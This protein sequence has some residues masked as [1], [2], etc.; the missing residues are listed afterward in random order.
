MK[1]RGKR[2]FMNTLKE[3]FESIGVPLYRN[4]NF[5]LDHY[6]QEPYQDNQDNQD[7]EKENPDQYI[8]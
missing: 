8:I 1:N 4:E 3:L 5:D 2:L 6:Y 7:N